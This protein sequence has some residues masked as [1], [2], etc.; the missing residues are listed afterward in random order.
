MQTL[1]FQFQKINWLIFPGSTDAKAYWICGGNSINPQWS[2]SKPDF[3]N[4][5]SKWIKDIE[6]EVGLQ[7]LIGLG[8]GAIE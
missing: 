4:C 6:N 7:V 8:G 1:S 5:V 2:T 3:S